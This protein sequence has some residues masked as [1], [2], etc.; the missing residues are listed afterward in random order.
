MTDPSTI[1]SRLS[2]ALEAEV[3][4]LRRGYYS[5]V[6]DERILADSYERL[7]AVLRALISED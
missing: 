3:A 1:A 6:V 5:E 2:E 4:I 7:A